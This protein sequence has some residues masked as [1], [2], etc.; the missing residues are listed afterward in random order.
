MKNVTS[1]YM[2][3]Y[4]YTHVDKDYIKVCALFDNASEVFT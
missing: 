4:V 2:Y 3:A 1:S